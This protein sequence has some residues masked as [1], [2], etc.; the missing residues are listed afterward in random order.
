VKY[1]VFKSRVVDFAIVAC[2]R[3][4]GVGTIL[5]YF[6]KLNNTNVAEVAMI[7][8][9]LKEDCAIQKA[10]TVLIIIKRKIRYG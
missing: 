6:K 5:E 1:R 7:D 8:K 3:Q 2:E 9:D 10:S 4:I